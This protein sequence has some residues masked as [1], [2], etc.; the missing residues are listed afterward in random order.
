MALVGF[1]VIRL[2]LPDPLTFDAHLLPGDSTAN[3]IDNITVDYLEIHDDHDPVPVTT[4]A[5]TATTAPD[6]VAMHRS[7]VFASPP[8]SSGAKAA[9]TMP[10][11][12]RSIPTAE[13]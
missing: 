3:L 2:T 6:T 8:A 13:K 1:R 11:V 10:S 5:E 12:S 9:P 4:D 7:S